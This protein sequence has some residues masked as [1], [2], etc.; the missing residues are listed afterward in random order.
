M[1]PRGLLMIEHRLIEKTLKLA[2]RESER[3]RAGRVD[4]L[5]IDTVVDFIRTYADR[6]H[7]GKEEDILFRE[8]EKKPLSQADAAAMREL[9]EEHTTARRTTGELVKANADFLAGREESRAV[10]FE[11]L[12]FLTGFYPK[13][14]AKEDKAFFPA[15]EKYF[16]AA[17]LEAMLAEFHEF[18]R[19]MIHEKYE[20]VYAALAKRG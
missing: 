20:G 10:I 15:T 13:H 6:T 8:L 12:Q 9:V 17:E 18:D 2:E 4:T 19:R 14:I 3:V 11:K 7:H 1:K 16:T 5:F